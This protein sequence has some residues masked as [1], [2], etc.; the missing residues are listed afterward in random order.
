MNELI[1][2]IGMVLYI[3]GFI[4]AA[5]AKMDGYSYD[6]IVPIVIIY[7]VGIFTVSVF[8]VNWWDKRH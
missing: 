7:Y 3:G 1:K 2:F 6:E 8:F 5:F 4:F